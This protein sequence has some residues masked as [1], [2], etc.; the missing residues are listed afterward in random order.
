[1]DQLK[2]PFITQITRLTVAFVGG[3]KSQPFT[4]AD[5]TGEPLFM[6][7]TSDGTTL[8]V[9]ITDRRVDETAPPAQRATTANVTV[10][11]KTNPPVQATI[12]GIDYNPARGL[13]LGMNVSSDLS[14]AE[15][16]IREKR[17]F[18]DD[19]IPL[20]FVLLENVDAGEP[21]NRLEWIKND[22]R[23][24]KG[25]TRTAASVY[26]PNPKVGGALGPMGFGTP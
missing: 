3:A 15:L 17:V 2:P 20:T 6:R 12:T 19:D 26:K 14:N 18:T 13:E 8:T 4:I 10:R 24:E 11:Y 21:R 16:S 25:D 1:M 5:Y 23:V 7:A 22:V 9:D